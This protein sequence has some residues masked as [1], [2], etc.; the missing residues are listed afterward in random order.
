MPTS[1]SGD[2]VRSTYVQFKDWAR[3]PRDPVTKELVLRSNKLNRLQ[4]WCVWP[5][6]AYGTNP[7]SAILS[8]LDVTES[9]RTDSRYK[10]GTDA[11]ARAFAKFRE[12]AWGD[13][14]ASLAVDLAESK[15]SLNLIYES[16]SRA[17]KFTLAV[18]RGRIGDAYASLKSNHPLKAK[19]SPSLVHAAS[20]NWLAYRLGVVPM[21][22]SIDSALQVIDN[23][24]KYTFSFCKGTSSMPFRKVI[25]HRSGS[26]SWHTV[27]CEGVYRVTIKAK[28]TVSDPALARL[29]QFGLTNP[30]DVAWE[31][32]PFSFLIDRVVKVGDYLSSF[33]DFVGLS[34]TDLSITESLRGSEEWVVTR[35]GWQPVG[36]VHLRA[37]THRKTRSKPSSLP[38]PSL[39]M[40]KGLFADVRKTADVAA[41]LV[42]TMKGL[43]GH[44]RG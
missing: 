34:F 27:S 26:S 31:L 29:N 15:Q 7:R 17:L 11:Y 21:I 13:A 6:A 33:D 37:L 10:F 22:G 1:Y 36:A 32:V 8:G 43:K 3:S 14:Q 35:E 24:L 2:D 44:S 28:V 5:S 40:G 4:T 19:G 18:K 23:P 16:L 42:Q 30:L 12:A 39:Q 20:Q 9:Y 38:V 41:L 25:D